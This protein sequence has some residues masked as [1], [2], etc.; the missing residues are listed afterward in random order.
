[1]ISDV[2]VSQI[3]CV[4]IT[5]VQFNSVRFS[6]LRHCRNAALPKPHEVTWGRNLERNDTQKVILFRLPMDR[7]LIN[8]YRFK[9]VKTNSIKCVKGSS[10]WGDYEYGWSQ[11]NLY[12]KSDADLSVNLYRIQ[13]SWSTEEAGHKLFISFTFLFFRN[14]IW[15]VLLFFL[16]FQPLWAF[17]LVLVLSLSLHF[18]LSPLIFNSYNHILS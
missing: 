1:M 14:V 11:D 18:T 13:V 17:A 5:T 4:I 12:E 2:W 7:G 8:H 16:V 6:L 15:E 3:H 9:S 10:V